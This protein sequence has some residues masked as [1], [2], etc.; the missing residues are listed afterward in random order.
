MIHGN[1]KISP[2]VVGSLFARLRLLRLLF[3]DWAGKR[4]PHT[5]WLTMAS[6]VFAAAYIIMPFDLISDF[7]PVIGWLDDTAVLYAVWLASGY[8]L[9]KYLQWK[10][11]GRS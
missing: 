3:G 2:G 6:I 11:G 1:K 8:D 9:K 7:I 4:Y 5:P 10:E